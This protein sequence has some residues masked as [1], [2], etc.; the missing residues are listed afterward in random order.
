MEGTRS[1]GGEEDSSRNLDEEEAAG[2]A[3]S[4]CIEGAEAG[5]SGT[6]RRQRDA[7]EAPA[8]ADRRYDLAGSGANPVECMRPRGE[9]G[10]GSTRTSASSR[11]KAAASEGS[12]TRTASQECRRPSSCS[13]RSPPFL[14][15]CAS[16]AS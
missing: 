2:T 13:D 1:G 16:C 14:G 6:Q 7:T 12:A 3:V 10:S 9:L 8:H 4:L 11:V 5:A 15:D